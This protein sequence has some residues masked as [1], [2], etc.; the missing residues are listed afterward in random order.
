M[1]RY[2]CDHCGSKQ[3]SEGTP[4]MHVSSSGEPV[5]IGTAYKC[6]ECKKWTTIRKPSPAEKED[7]DW[8][9]GYSIY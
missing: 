7:N 3:E 5:H 9:N 4:L 8:L 2:L 6:L 1:S